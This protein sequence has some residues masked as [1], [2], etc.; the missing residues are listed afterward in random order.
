MNDL[1]EL[2]RGAAWG[3]LS[4]EE[5]ERFRR[6]LDRYLDTFEG[7]EAI[8]RAFAALEG[9]ASAQ[10][11]LKDRIENLAELR[12]VR[13]R[14]GRPGLAC[15][16][17]AALVMGIDP[18]RSLPAQLS[19]SFI[20][21]LGKALSRHRV[22]GEKTEVSFLGELV[23]PWHIELR[24][25]RRRYLLEAVVAGESLAMPYGEEKRSGRL[26]WRLVVGVLWM[27]GIEEL[28]ELNGKRT[29]LAGWRREVGEMI[30]AEWGSE[31]IWVS[32]LAPLGTV[33]DLG[34]RRFRLAELG[35]WAHQHQARWDR[36]LVARI[37]R[38]G[39]TMLIC[40]LDGERPVA[41][42]RWPLDGREDLDRIRSSCQVALTTAG[43]ALEEK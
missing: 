38:R 35:I 22:V 21:R 4:W 29:D 20:K 16:V 37:I 11:Q 30:E 9:E 10:G 5:E 19:A 26:A 25:S 36:P 39:W 18:G 13:L 43:V 40:L 6:L 28:D 33:I 41:E 27:E 15:L 2:A 34:G 12:E 7:Q 31:V 17:G 24:P 32:P 8:D 3:D 14:D 1:A 23:A 42:Y